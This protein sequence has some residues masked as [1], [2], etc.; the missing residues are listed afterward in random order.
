ML[1]TNCNQ[2]VNDIMKILVNIH[3]TKYKDLDA[4]KI[5]VRKQKQFVIVILEILIDMKY[6]SLVETCDRIVNASLLAQYWLV[7]FPRPCQGRAS[8]L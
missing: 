1:H 2:Q 6:K 5:C 7:H 3:S 4:N 8:S